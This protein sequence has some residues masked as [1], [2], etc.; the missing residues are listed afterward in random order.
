M[1]MDVLL[2]FY[3]LEPK[4][5]QMLAPEPYWVVIH[6]KVV[7]VV[8]KHMPMVRFPVVHEP[9]WPEIHKKSMKVNNHSCRHSL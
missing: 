5:H 3:M 6:L 2:V 9:L 4:Q 1:L 7:L 8:L